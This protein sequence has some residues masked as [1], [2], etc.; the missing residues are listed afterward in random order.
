MR[1]GSGCHHRHKR[2]SGDFFGVERRTVGERGDGGGVPES[3]VGVPESGVG[4]PESGV[5]VP[6]SGV[7][8]P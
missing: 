6:E 3:G 5:G 7:G 2:E 8:V 1:W 4:V